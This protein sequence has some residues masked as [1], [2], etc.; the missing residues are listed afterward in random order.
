MIWR[1]RGRDDKA[2]MRYVIATVGA[3][4][5]FVAVFILSALLVGMGGGRGGVRLLV[6]F[7]A[8]IGGRF[9]TWPRQIVDKGVCHAHLVEDESS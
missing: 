2:A 4:F 8:I 6:G 9:R 7:V 5:I 3:L 1:Y